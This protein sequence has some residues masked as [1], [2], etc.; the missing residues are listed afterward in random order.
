LSI[1]PYTPRIEQ[2]DDGSL[3]LWIKAVPGAS[4]DQIAGVLGDRLKVRVATPPEAGKANK[5]ICRLL[6]ES[7]GLKP[8]QVAIE[9]GHASPEKVVRLVG[10]TAADLPARLAALKA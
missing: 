7:L 5:A 1:S 6:A 10:L 2:A 3:R 4:R 8:N 9:S